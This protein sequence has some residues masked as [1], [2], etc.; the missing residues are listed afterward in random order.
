MWGQ[1]DSN[2]STA[3]SSFWWLYFAYVEGNGKFSL[4]ILGWQ[5]CH[6]SNLLSNGVGKVLCTAVATF[7]SL[8]LFQTKKKKT[9]MVQRCERFNDSWYK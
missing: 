6:L 8:I 1:G 4:N 5:A 3:I 9:D 2:V 7:E